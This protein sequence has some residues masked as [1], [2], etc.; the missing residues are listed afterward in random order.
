[1]SI[2]PG[3]PISMRTRPLA[4]A[5]SS[6]RATLNRLSPNSSAISI[7]ERAVEVVAARHRGGQ[8]ELGRPAQVPSAATMPALSL[9]HL[10]TVARILAASIDD[11]VTRA[12]SLHA[13]TAVLVLSTAAGVQEDAMK[14][15][16]HD[17]W[18]SCSRSD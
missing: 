15:L 14:R 11:V 3:W 1:M 16:G 13:I 18:R 4:R 2:A 17:A 12:T 7:L 5:S 9:A 10:S 8:H 6:S